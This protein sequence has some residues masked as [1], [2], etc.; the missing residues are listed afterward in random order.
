MARAE[1]DAANARSDSPRGD[2]DLRLTALLFDMVE[3]RAAGKLRR[4]SA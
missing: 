3:A 1:D 2:N 4:P